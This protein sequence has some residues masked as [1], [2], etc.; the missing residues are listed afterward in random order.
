MVPACPIIL[1]HFVAGTTPNETDGTQYR[2]K[3]CVL[4]YDSCPILHPP[5]YDFRPCRGTPITPKRG[6][7]SHPTVSCPPK[8]SRYC[9]ITKCCRHPLRKIKDRQPLTKSKLTR[10][11]AGTNPGATE[12]TQ[13]ATGMPLEDTGRC[14]RI[15]LEDTGKCKRVAL[16]HHKWLQS[17]KKTAKCAPPRP[18]LTP[19]ISRP[20]H[21]SP[22]TRPYPLLDLNGEHP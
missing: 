10:S 22:R 9:D 2:Y 7:M 13:F 19:F 8:Q 14:K 15:A 1:R 16:E 11:C 18:P 17:C 3:K 12:Y 21:E 20:Y 4:S 6:T 5:R